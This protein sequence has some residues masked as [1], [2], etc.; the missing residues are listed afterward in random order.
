MIIHSN[1]KETPSRLTLGE[2]AL[3]LVKIGHASDRVTYYSKKMNDR[4][5][6][7]KLDFLE[8]D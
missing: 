7:K 4:L 1:T 6:A 3:I 8:E 5:R 2:D